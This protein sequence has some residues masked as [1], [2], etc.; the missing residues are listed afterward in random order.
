MEDSIFKIVET[1]KQER[2]KHLNKIYRELEWSFAHALR[3]KL[4]P[5]E[6][7]FIEMEIKFQRFLLEEISMRTDLLGL[8]GT[9]VDWKNSLPLLKNKAERLSFQIDYLN[10]FHT[11]LAFALTIFILLSDKL[12]PQNWL[13]VLVICIFICKVF[14]DRSNL[15][16]E[17]T[18]YREVTNLIEANRDIFK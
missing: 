2:S 4:K 9:A 8:R 7:H 10:Y 11:F 3:R 15:R 17:L 13:L 12:D 5:S 1:Y 16:R 6:E 14:S 18:I